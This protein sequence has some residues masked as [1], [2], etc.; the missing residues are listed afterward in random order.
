MQLVVFVPPALA[1]CGVLGL[2]MRQRW[3]PVIAL[4][5]NLLLVM[6][7][8]WT[9]VVK[10]THEFGY[11]TWED[12]IPEYFAITLHAL[13]VVMIFLGGDRLRSQSPATSNVH[14]T[15]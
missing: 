7:F 9:I 13:A 5:G 14:S 3:S 12:F 8:G 11:W 4:V 15:S 1:V 2:Y 6:I 10:L